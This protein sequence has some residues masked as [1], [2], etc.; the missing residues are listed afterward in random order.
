MIGSSTKIIC[1]M[2]SEKA[3]DLFLIKE[4]IEAGKIKSIVDRRYPQEQAAPAHRYVEEGHKK[5][6]VIITL[7]PDNKI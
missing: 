7:E 2:A 1:A 6:N 4:L 5:G 3:E